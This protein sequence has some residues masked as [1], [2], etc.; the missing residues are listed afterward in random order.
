MSEGLL[1]TFSK[2]KPL[3]RDDTIDY[4]KSFSASLMVQI[5]ALKLKKQYDEL[6]EKEQT[7]SKYGSLTV[8][9]EK[10]GETKRI[11][12]QFDEKT[13]P[14]LESQWF[15]TGL[16]AMIGQSVQALAK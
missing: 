5:D 16:P 3:E 2:Q 1:N 6:L 13:A 8:I 15:V 7:K 9:T 12:F 14:L 11:I 10:I 4:W